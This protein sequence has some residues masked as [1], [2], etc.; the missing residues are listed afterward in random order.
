MKTTLNHALLCVLAASAFLFSCNK[1][2]ASEPSGP[3]EPKYNINVTLGGA[4]IEVETKTTGDASTVATNEAKVNS[5]QVLVFR[6]DFLDAYGTANASSVSVSCTAGTRTI[7]AVVNG[8]SLSSVTSLAA[9][10]ST[11]VDLSANSASSFVMVGSKTETLPGT[12]SV[13]IPVSRMVSRIVLKKITRNFTAASLQGLTFKVD[14]IYVVNAAG[15]FN[16][17]LNGSPTKW[18]NENKDKGELTALLRDAPGATI[19]NNSSYSTPH[20]FYVMPNSAAS[21]TTRLVIVATL[22]TQKYYYPVNLP[23]MQYNKSYEITG[24]TIKRGGSDDPNTPVTS[25][26]IS[27]GISVNNWVTS[28]IA[29]QLI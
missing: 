21:K 11:M 5:L 10:E 23:A 14:S 4:A 19:A 7:Y 20:Y 17:K 24:V 29:E 28:N 22:G 27:F 25:S 15:N 9:L 1:F 26:D 3:E 13:T 18:Y 2:E 8:P 12:N 16:Y 6:G